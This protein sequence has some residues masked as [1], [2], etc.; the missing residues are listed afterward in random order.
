MCV[1]VC[2]L[3]RVCVRVCA[4][5]PEIVI[6][7]QILSGIVLLI[8]NTNQGHI[9]TMFVFLFVFNQ[10]WRRRQKQTERTRM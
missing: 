4:H 8:E 9:N 7:G 6:V 3:V 5:A 10:Q 1:C 2:V